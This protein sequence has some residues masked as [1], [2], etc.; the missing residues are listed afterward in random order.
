[1]DQNISFS[2]HN[3]TCS[4]DK[5]SRSFSSRSATGSSSFRNSTEFCLVRSERVAQRYYLL[6][7]IGSASDDEVKIIDSPSDFYRR[8]APDAQ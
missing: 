8:T 2:Q 5:I 3:M 6:S 7:S 1:M 4:S